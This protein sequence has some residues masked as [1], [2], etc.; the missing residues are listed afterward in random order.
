MLSNL[1]PGDKLTPDAVKLINT[2][3]RGRSVDFTTEFMAS[4]PAVLKLMRSLGWND[5]QNPPEVEPGKSVQ[6]VTVVDGQVRGELSYLNR[7]KMSFDDAPELIERGCMIEDVEDE[8][9]G[10]D[11]FYTGWAYRMEQEDCT[12]WEI[13]SPKR[14]IAWQPL[15]E[16][17][18]RHDT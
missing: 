15:P 3:C 9:G 5:A 12:Y 1:N 16:W 13:V 10:V 14:V 18:A 7:F 4:I 2:V 8:F 6:V 17:S 11:Y